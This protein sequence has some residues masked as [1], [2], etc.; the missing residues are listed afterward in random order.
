MISSLIPKEVR[1]LR[2]ILESY[3]GLFDGQFNYDATPTYIIQQ[4]ELKLIEWIK[5]KSYVGW[6]LNDED[7]VFG[8]L[9]YNQLKWDT[10]HFDIPMERLDYLIVR[11]Q[12]DARILLS[13][14]IREA[15]GRGIKHISSRVSSTEFNLLSVFGEFGFKHLDSKLMLRFNCKNYLKCN[16]V[17]NIFVD[18]IINKDVSTLIKIIGKSTLKNRFSQDNHINQ[19]SVPY[20]Y[21]RWLKKLINDQTASILVAKDGNEICGFVA[22]TVGIEIYGDLDIIKLKPGFINLIEVVQEYQGKGLGKFLLS[23]AVN[24]LMEAGCSVVYAN[25]SLTNIGSVLAF[26]RIGF[27]VFSVLSEVRLWT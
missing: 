21:E 12:K 19:K 7:K 16:S 24:E 5:D 6:I 8:I 26:Q 22:F 14:Y 18:S 27:E 11:S 15:K 20:V 17:S 2:H 13:S 9:L 1:R 25:T 10:K 3:K 23:T 4:F